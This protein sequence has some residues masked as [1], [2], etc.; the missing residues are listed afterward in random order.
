M[1]IDTGGGLTLRKYSYVIPSLLLLVLIVYGLFS[2]Q[3]NLRQVRNLST[4]LEN[5][6]LQ[7]NRAEVNQDVELTE[8]QQKA[9][10][11]AFQNL[12]DARRRLVDAMLEVGLITEDEAQYR[13][14]HI[15]LME[16]YRT[17][18]V[19]PAPQMGAGFRR[20]ARVGQAEDEKQSG[21]Q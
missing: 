1:Q 3:G 4:R 10:D 18:W 15:A 9:M 12:I 14:D 5:L 6:Q 19:P 11:D 16:K 2:L 13:K 7:V 8:E 21:N 17:E 20:M